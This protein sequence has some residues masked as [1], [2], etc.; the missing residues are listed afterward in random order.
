MLLQSIA[1]LVTTPLTKNGVMI[2]QTPSNG[3]TQA[4]PW[5]RSYAAAKVSASTAAAM[6]TMR[7]LAARV[8]WPSNPTTHGEMAAYR[9]ARKVSPRTVTAVPDELRWA[10]FSRS[11]TRSGCPAMAVDVNSDEPCWI[12]PCCIVTVLPPT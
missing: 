11:A 9:P 6:P 3:V 1:V 5:V 10:Y 12:V 4:M 2:N 7:L 8:D